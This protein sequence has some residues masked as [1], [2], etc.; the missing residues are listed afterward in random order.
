MWKDHKKQIIFN[1]DLNLNEDKN[2][3][4]T[5]ILGDGPEIWESSNEVIAAS[6]LALLPKDD[7]QVRPCEKWHIGGWEI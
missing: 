4:E 5:E 7:G 1:S 6:L 3:E 2:S